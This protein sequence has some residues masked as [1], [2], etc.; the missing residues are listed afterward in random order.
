MAAGRRRGRR[1][2]GV[3]GRPRLGHRRVVRPGSRPPR[4]LRT[5]AAAASCT[6]PASSTP[7]S[8]G[9][10]RARRWRWIRSSG[11]CWR[12]R[13]RRSS[14]PGIDPLSL[15]GSRTGVFVGVMYHDYA[16]RLHR[17]PRGARGLP[18]QRQRR[19]HRLRPAGLHV[20][21][22]GPGG[23]RGHGVLVV[24]GGAASGGAG[25]AARRVFA[26]AG[27]RGDGDGDAAACSWSSA[28]SVGWRA[29][30]R[31]KS[32]AAAADG[33]GWSEGVGVLVVERL[34]DARRNGH[35][36][37][38]VVRG[39][40]VNQDGASNGLTAPNGPSQERVIRAGAGRRRAGRRRGGCGRGARHRDAAG[41]SDRGAGVAGDLRA[42]SWTAPLWLGS[43]KSNI[44]HAQ[45]AAGRGRCDQD[46]AWRC[47]TACCRGPC[48]WTSR[49]RTWTG[50]S[51]AV[52][53]LTEPV[54]WPDT[55][56]AAPGRGVLVRDQRH[57]RA[58]HP[59]GGAGS[60]A[61]GAGRGSGSAGAAVPWLLSAR[62]TGALRRRRPGC[63][64]VAG[65]RPDPLDV[66]YSL[67]TT[68]AGARSTARWL[69]SRD[70]LA[71]LAR[72][73]AATRTSSP[74]PVVD[75]RAGVGVLRPGLAAR[76]DGRELYARSRCSR[77][78]STRCARQLRAAASG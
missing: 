77:R 45:A 42:G 53:L 6:T 55:R 34:S 52:E 35:R 78:R 43:L 21:L 5:P 37:L 13:G 7:G 57:Q 54:D 22:R 38:A 76:R 70:G 49:R 75:G 30:G 14:T 1:D 65:R 56:P 64:S 3:P 20:R 47:G 51:G 19:E 11:C 26:G 27:R 4:H 50:R 71:A 17:E 16:S 23:D 32:F 9:S 63:V 59:G 24:V 67:A 62:P 68:R 40:A 2:R 41:R 72:R 69:H 15:R 25:A 12:R 33:T 39:I 48:T 36:V 60:T 18:G 10:R 66:G 29:D 46:G 73:R 61:T 44:G 74:G 31:C 8:S 28:G 58:R